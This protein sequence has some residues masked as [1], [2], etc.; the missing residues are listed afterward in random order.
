MTVVESFESRLASEEPSVRLALGGS[1]AITLSASSIP[2]EAA[3]R[4]A[5]APK[6]VSL[7]I[8]RRDAGRITVQFSAAGYA[9]LVES[10]VSVEALVSGRWAATAPIALTLTDTPRNASR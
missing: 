5:N 6:G 8:L 9:R 10:K 2:E 1:T 7:R 3:I 4:L